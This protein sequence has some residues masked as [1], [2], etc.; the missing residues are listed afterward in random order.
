MKSD[1]SWVVL[2]T[3]NGQGSGTVKFNVLRNRTRDERHGTITA[4]IT[5]DCTATLSLTQLPAE[6][7]ENF[8]YYVKTD[9]DAL[10][11]GL[12][13]EEATTLPTALE[14]AGDGDVIC[15]A[16]GTYA[17]VALLTGGETEEEKTFEI[18]SNFTLEGGYPADAV[19]GAVADPSANETVLSGNLGAVSAYHV[20][21][22]TASKSTLHT[23]VLKNLTISDGVGYKTNEELRRVVGGAVIDAALGGGLFVGVSNLSVVNCRIADNEAC[24]SGGVHV[25]VGAEVSFEGCTIANNTASNNGGGIWNQGAV[26]YMNGCTIS[27][28]VS[29]QQAAGFYSID[30]GGGRS[31]SR[32]SNT[33]ISDNDNTRLNT[34]RSGGGA[35]IR[36]GSDA[37]FTNCTFT[38]IK[39]ATAVPSRVTGPERFPPRR[40]ASVAPSRI[41]WPMTAAALCSLTTIMRMSW[42]GT[43]SFRVTAVR[44]TVATWEYWQ[45]LTLRMCGSSHRLPAVSCST[46]PAERSEDGASVPRRCS[47]SWAS[48]PEA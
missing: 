47:A 25:Y 32:I 46:M 7:S 3:V 6:A 17:P 21:T 27:G 4:Y 10:A 18:H 37:V 28:N 23:A 26:V 12:S 45:A 48:T 11:S 36:A 39:P 40:S 35:Y 5:D 31:I 29:G 24:H 15:L 41:T 38:A 43:R 16:A 13:W 42:L 22:V 20:V 9:G 2:T 14:N 1:V 30:S 44:P 19:T 33:T 34:K 8:T